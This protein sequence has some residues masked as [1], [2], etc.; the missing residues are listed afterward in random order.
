MDNKVT[1]SFVRLVKVLLWVYLENVVAHLEANWFN[2]GR[3][4]FA[5]LLD[6]AESFVALAIELWESFLPLNSNFLEHI[7][8]D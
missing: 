1:L 2:F 8:G 4:F 5:R 6:V 7:W 3:D